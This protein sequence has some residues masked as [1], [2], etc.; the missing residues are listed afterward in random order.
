MA[1]RARGEGRS[2]G[3]DGTAYQRAPPSSK[4]ALEIPIRAIDAIDAEIANLCPFAFNAS[5]SLLIKNGQ[6]VTPSENYMADIFCED[7]TITR[8]ERNLSAPHGAEVID[9]TGKF[10]FPGF[11]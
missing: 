9:A 1:W 10:V 11:I 2:L 7:E 5:M 8:I 4:T 6:I 3:C